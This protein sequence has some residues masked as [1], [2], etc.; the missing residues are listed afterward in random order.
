MGKVRIDFIIQAWVPTPEGPTVQE[1]R[2]AVEGIEGSSPQL[3]D[4][5]QRAAANGLQIV[6]E[7]ALTP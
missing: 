3:V 1:A 6:L 2:W 7:K 5:V 4:A